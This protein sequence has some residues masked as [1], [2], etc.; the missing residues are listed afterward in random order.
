MKYS[1]PAID[2]NVNITSPNGE[3]H[4]LEFDIDK[5]IEFGIGMKSITLSDTTTMDGNVFTREWNLNVS[6]ELNEGEVLK[7][8]TLEGS[9]RYEGPV[10]TLEVDINNIVLDVNCDRN[11]RGGSIEVK[12]PEHT[13]VITFENT[14]SCFAWLSIDGDEPQ[15]VDMCNRKK[16]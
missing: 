2:G 3:E 7:E 15:K 5:T 14:C 8:I 16:I 13:A 11:P 4:E 12:G 9:G 10:R 1:I 6:K